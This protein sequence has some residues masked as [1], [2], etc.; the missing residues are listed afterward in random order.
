MSYDFAV[1]PASFASK[2][3][4]DTLAAAV[5]LFEQGQPAQQPDP[6]MVELIAR[7][8]QLGAGEDE[9]GWLAIW[10][11]EITDFGV[12]LPMRF[13]GL[14]AHALQLLQLTIELGLVLVDLSGSV[15]FPPMGTPARISL[16]G[17]WTLLANLT[18]L[19]I[20]RLLTELPA[21]NPFL[22]IE[23]ADGRYIQTY[24]QDGSFLL[25]YRDDTGHF[26]TTVA[27]AADV[28]DR[29]TGWLKQEPDWFV[30]LAWMP[31]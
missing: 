23:V 13:Q 6:V 1:L 8:T 19:D 24:D 9:T 18:R 11:L 28:A 31:V 27:T 20:E 16:G 14:E 7:L 30:G 21:D 4:E 17:D 25:E 29:M 12:C 15:V 5:T 10:P 3:D 2:T 22:I 26:G